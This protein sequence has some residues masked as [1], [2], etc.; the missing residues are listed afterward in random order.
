MFVKAVLGKHHLQLFSTKDAWRVE[1]KL[2]LMHIDVC[3]LMRTH[4]M[5]KTKNLRQKAS[6]IPSKG[7]SIGEDDNEPIPTFYKES[8]SLMSPGSPYS[9]SVGF[10]EAMKEEARRK[11]WKKRLNKFISLLVTVQ[12]APCSFLFYVDDMI[13]TDDTSEFLEWFIQELGNE[14]A[15]MD[16]GL[17]NYF[18]G[19][20]VHS[21]DSGLFL[22]QLKYAQ[23][24]VTRAKMIGCKPISTPMAI[25]AHYTASSRNPYYDPTHYQSIVGAL[26]YLT[27]TRLDLSY[28]VN[29]MC[30]LMQAPTVGH[31]RGVKHI[32]QYG[33][34]TLDYGMKVLRQSSLELNGFSDVYWAGCPFTRRST[35]S[36]CTFLGGNCISWPAKKQ[37]AV[38]RSS[39]RVEYR[40]MASTAAEITWLSTLLCDIGVPLQLLRSFT[41]II[42]VLCR[43]QSIECS[44]VI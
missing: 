36:I 4:L 5:L 21:S 20:E 39:A 3:G 17:L 18:L 13:L 10:E 25:K 26:Q 12:E 1:E 29:L 43:W 31:D 7:M 16:L 15:I 44:M 27:F 38:A 28:S 37:T 6:Q 32:L 30:Q 40:Y 35:T 19:I 33:S 9:S 24:I 14:F 11:E 42:S 22:C 8:S 2:E 41:V 34:G 23:D